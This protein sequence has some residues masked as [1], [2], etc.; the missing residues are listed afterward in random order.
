MILSYSV[1][2]LGVG[3]SLLQ[4]F[5][6]T[7]ASVFG[8]SLMQSVIEVF[9]LFHSIC[10]YGFPFLLSI[11]RD[12]IL[13]YQMTDI[14]ERYM[15]CFSTSCLISVIIYIVNFYLLIAYIRLCGNFSFM[16]TPCINSNKYFVVQLMHSIYKL[17]AS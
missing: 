4:A 9:Y 7:G 14:H 17:N 16:V 3:I 11:N 12:T 5:C 6:H 13:K 15:M 2:F 1:G 8:S 10:L